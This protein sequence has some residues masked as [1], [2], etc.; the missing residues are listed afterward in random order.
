MRENRRYKDHADF[1]IQG[2]ADAVRGRLRRQAARHRRAQPRERPR[3]Q[4]AADPDHAQGLPRRRS[5]SSAYSFVSMVQPLRSA[6]AAARRVPEPVASWPA[7]ASCPATAAACRRRRPRSSPTRARSPTRRAALF[8]AR[9]NSISAGPCASRAASAI[10]FI[11]QHDRVHASATRRCPRRS[12]RPRSAPPP[13]SCAARSRAA[14]P[15]PPSTSTRAS[16]RWAW[17][18]TPFPTTCL[19]SV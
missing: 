8:G 15:A 14:S 16:R 19:A 6:A 3:G 4:E 13:R 1:T 17:P 12:R 2:V 5:A 10:G 18:W 9:V 7:S 11:E